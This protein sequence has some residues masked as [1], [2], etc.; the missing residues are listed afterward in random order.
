MFKNKN[1]T[2][3]TRENVATYLSKLFCKIF[4]V[5]EGDEEI[6]YKNLLSMD[7]ATLQRELELIDTYYHN[8]KQAYTSA[9][10]KMMK[11]REEAEATMSPPMNF[12]F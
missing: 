1:V 6:M 12:N 10:G 2:L 4:E 3:S 11:Q 7:D 9:V 5:K 8:V